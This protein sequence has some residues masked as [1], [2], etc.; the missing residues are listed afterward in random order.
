M[1][2]VE[3][4]VKLRA[5]DLRGLETRLSSMGAMLLHPREFEDN[6]LYD[7]PGMTLQQSGAML[8]VR[9]HARGGVLTHKEKGRIMDGAK[10]RD[11][12]EVEV[13]DAGTLSAILEKLGLVP[14]FRY[15]KYRTTYQYQDLL[16]TL[17]ET[18]IGIFFELEGPKATINDLARK[19]GYS[20]ADYITETYRDL[21]LSV[22]KEA[23]E[24]QDM[25]FEVP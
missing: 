10:V 22:R 8:R 13:A 17:D 20:P 15:Q 3:I 24:G 23:G 21:F 11:E 5:G 9:T 7:F 1:K 4:E 16:L 12:I 18:P 6:R 19:L 2:K 25:L 14:C